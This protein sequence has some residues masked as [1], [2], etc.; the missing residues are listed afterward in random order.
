MQTASSWIK[1]NAGQY[2]LYRVNYPPLQWMSLALAATQSEA[3]QP[4]LSAPDLAGLLDDA[5]HLAQIGSADIG[6]FLNLTRCLACACQ[7][8]AAEL[9][10]SLP[11]QHC[12]PPR[13]VWLTSAPS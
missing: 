9:R 3:G 11:S 8:A 5:F 13:S 1:L 10:R 4:A 7:P 6:T 12:V 2:G